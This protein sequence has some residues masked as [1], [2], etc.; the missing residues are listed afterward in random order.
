MTGDPWAGEKWASGRIA[1]DNK[2]AGCV[3]VGLTL[4]WNAI[5]WGVAFPIVFLQ[6][7]S[8]G[9]YFVLLFPLV[10]LLL[11][12]LT[13]RVL[14]RRRRYGSPVFVLATRPGVVGRALAG[15]I[16]VERGLEP[17]ADIRLRLKCVRVVTTGSGKS[18]STTTTVLWEAERQ[19]PGALGEGA[20]VRIP[21]AFA[22]PEDAT[23]TDNR[24]ASDV[25]RWD[26]EAKAVVPGIDFGVTFEVP[27]YFTSESATPLTEDERRRLMG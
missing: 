18:R 13:V 11:L 2:N 1:E 23:P 5:S 19:L 21:V 26:L 17:E 3:L 8:A 15:E 27:V 14:L 10:G 9:R 25:V 12:V 22:I 7:D 20:G 4:V 24:H 16:R 6:D